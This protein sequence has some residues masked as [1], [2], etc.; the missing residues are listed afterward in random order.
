MNNVNTPETEE[1][2][3]S[4]HDDDEGPSWGSVIVGL[5][6]G[7]AGVVLIFYRYNQFQHPDGEVISITKIEMLLYKVSGKRFQVL[8]GAYGLIS[9][10]GF[11]LAVSNII[12]LRKRK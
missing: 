1:Q 9:L 11:W 2:R 8:L 5:L 6:L 10:A 4:Q 7:I 12:H 3:L